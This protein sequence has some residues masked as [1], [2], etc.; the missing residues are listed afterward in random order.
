MSRQPRIHEPLP[1]SFTEVI[2]AIA[3]QHKPAVQSMATRPF[4]KWVGGKRSILPDLL[5]RMPERY[6]TYREPFIGGG[7]LFFA[8]QPGRAYLSDINFNLVLSYQS[9]RDD[10]DGLIALLKEHQEKHCKENYLKARERLCTE[11]H[12]T[13][14]AALFIYLNKTCFNGLYRVNRAGQFNVPMGSYTDPSLFEDDVIRNDSKLLQGVTI[15]QHGFSQCP[16]AREDFFYLDP[17]YHKVYAQY[18]SSGFGETEHKRLAEWCGEIHHAGAF[19]ML[20]N[21]DT[22]FVRSLYRDF[23]IESVS[24]SRSVSCKSHQRGKEDELVIRN[25]K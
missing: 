20:S 2:E 3:N 19:F 17:P 14:I 18:D 8:V 10:V 7:A 22:P 25:Y 12:A 1:Y 4:L 6:Q 24:A 16:I 21:S 23:H 9:V 11:K 5:A 15:T 13:K